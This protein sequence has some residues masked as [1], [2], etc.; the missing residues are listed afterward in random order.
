MLFPSHASRLWLSL[1]A[2]L[3][4]GNLFAQAVG[5]Y[6]SVASGNWG[7]TATWNTWN[8]T[9]WVAAGAAPNSTN[10]V[11]TI[12]AAHTVTIAA[13]VTIDQVIV[14]GTLTSNGAVPTTIA[15]GTG[16]DVTINGTFTDNYQAATNVITWAAGATW[17]MGA[18]GTLLKTTGSSS[19]N[20]QSSYQGGITNIPATSNWIIR[21]NATAVPF[22][23]TN[24]ATGSVYPNLTVENI[25]GTVYTT[26]AAQ[27]ITGNT[28]YV[29]IK[30]N[31]DIGGAGSNVVDFLNNNTNASPTIVWGNV[32]VRAG[33]TMRNYGTGFEVRGDLIVNGTISYDA[34]DGRKIVFGG[35]INQTVSGTGALNVWDMTLN[36][37][38]G[39]VTLN[40]A[41]TVDNL[42]TFTSGIIFTSSVNL[43]TIA[44]AGSV[45]GANNSSFVSGPIK[46]NGASAFTFPVGKN[47]DY[48]PLSISSS[49]GSTIFT[50]NFNT[51]A[52]WSLNVVTGAEGADANFFQIDDDEGGGITPNLGAPTS[53]GV[54]VNGNNTLHVTSVF[55]PAGGAAYDAGG[56]CGLLFCPQADRRCESPV[57]NCSGQT[58]IQVN[59]N[60][61]ENGQTT[62]DNATLWYFDGASWSQVDDMPKTLT[63]CSGQG[64]WTTRSITLPASAN[65]NPN[66]RIAFRW[67][68]N[69][70]GAGTDPSFAVDDITISVSPDPFTCEYYYA[71][72]QT[73]FNNVLVPSLN[74][75]SQ[76]E[77]WVLNR[78]GSSTSKNV[79][80]SW[81]ANSCGVTLLSDLRVAR[82]D[83]AVWQNH[84][85]GATTG[86]TA[87][88]TVV[89]SAPVTS[90]S[91]FTLASVSSQNPLPVTFVDFVAWN[92]DEINEL[93]WTTASEVNNDYFIVERADATGE[94]VPI[95]RVEGNGTT[96]E[97]HRY[98]YTDYS[99]VEGLN[100]YRI[101][102]VD[103]NGTASYSVNRTI[104]MQGD[105]AFDILSIQTTYQVL[106]VAVIA[107]EGKRIQMEV[108]DIAGR[109][110]YSLN[111]EVTSKPTHFATSALNPGVYL[112]AVSD[113]EKVITR[114]VQIVG[115]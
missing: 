49:S 84:G 89:T 31:F 82:W 18:A 86:T 98:R 77:Y 1:V 105:D 111:Q 106:D 56:L 97:L 47:S 52:G 44:S 37:T 115:D 92:D 40:R 11:I 90:F 29:T 113:G 110:V 75:I 24:P 80:L 91:P 67:V 14:N 112:V 69:D 32:T 51:G 41:V 13:N 68:N 83:G 2:F 71:D 21:R 74:H 109:M 60:Y 108:F 85:N 42:A 95:G 53:C 88:G 70:D 103:Y 19:N 57:I 58:N 26:A 36:K 72:P 27:S 12:Q 8:G 61:I 104:D 46:Y 25:G 107:D 22:S 33:N 9:A 5:D 15:N 43:L 63:G 78:N 65:N 3:A 99:P 94:F 54:A 93:E 6:Q 39:S 62:F 102:Q 81:D 4:A 87:A 7:T 59:F 101:R 30:G 38:A 34:N 66:V 79:T 20:W 23:S 16:V 17:Q 50:E 48:Q 114:R 28:A 73:T 100:T 96:S 45:T 64:L 10:G 55:N 35:A 76:C